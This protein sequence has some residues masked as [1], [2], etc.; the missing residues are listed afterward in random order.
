[1][2]GERRRPNDPG[3]YEDLAQEWWRPRGAFTPLHWLSAARAEL[4]PK[5]PASGAVLVDLAC[6][7]GLL[8]PHLDGLGYHHVGIDIGT[9]ATRLARAHGVDAVQG[10]VRHLPF[11]SESVDVVVAGEIFEHVAELAATV[12]EIGRVLRPGGLLVCDT[13]ADTRRC[14]FVMITLGE[15]L[16]FVPR[17]VHDRSLLVDP[18]RLQALCEESSITLSV[19]GIRP[20]IPQF[21]SWLLRRRDDVAMRPTHSTGIVYQGVGVKAGPVA[22]SASTSTAGD[23]VGHVAERARALSADLDPAEPRW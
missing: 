14:A 6:G 12:A 22:S 5:A 23:P 17:G 3:L 8:A 21:V 10:D 20:S 4:V 9:S 15:R 7:G 2:H 16:S 19:Q 13:L 1:V 11:R 18:G